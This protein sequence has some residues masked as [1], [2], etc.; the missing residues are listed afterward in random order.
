VYAR[1]L[2]TVETARLLNITTWRLR[3]LV[4]S[5]KIAAPA[6]NSALDFLWTASDIAAARKALAARARKTAVQEA[7]S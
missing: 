2:T 3:Y 6:R 1:P 4:T 5:G 7:V